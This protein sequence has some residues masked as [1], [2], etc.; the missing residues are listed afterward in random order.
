MQ[1]IDGNIV[2]SASDITYFSECQHRTWL[3]RLNLDA[4]MKKTDDD[5]Q[6]KLL[7]V[8]GDIHE[9]DFFAKLQKK[10]ASCVEID[11]SLTAEQRITSTKQAIKAG[12]E[13]IFQ[14][15][16]RRGNL[17]GH[18]DFLLK[19]DEKAPN[20]QW[21]YEVADTKLAR[22]TKAK[23][24]LQLCFYSDLLSDITGQLPQHMHV[25]LGNGKRESFRVADYIYYYRQLLERYLAFVA[26]YPEATPP[27]PSPC[28]HC[29]L[30]PWR[31]RCDAKRIK[32]DHLSAVANISRQQIIRLEKAGINT[33]AKLA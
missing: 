17:I 33:L 31:E 30:C 20:G 19:L 27:Y 7:Q 25:E 1:K 8:K 29:S 28:N 14:A 32:D 2:F 24:I 16:L 6:S 13:V 21:L 9:N 10:Y 11:K 15:S 5:E 12:A 26:G 18:S 4:P 22:S 3:D 23:F